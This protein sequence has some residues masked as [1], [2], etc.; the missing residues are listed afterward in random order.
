MTTPG[1]SVELAST[2]LRSM[3][4]ALTITITDPR[5]I[6]VI[7]AKA[8]ERGISESEV[9]ES[10]FAR[11]HDTPDRLSRATRSPEDIAAR[12]AR[13]LELLRDIH[14]AV[15]DDARAFD[16]DAWLYDEHGLPR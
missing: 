1:G 4:M 2:A 10:A 5:T 12:K 16:H 14:A 11:D 9:I 15:T 7:R 13:A 3:H 6:A 8:A